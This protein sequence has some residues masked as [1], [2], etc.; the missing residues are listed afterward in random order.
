MSTSI[1]ASE[2]A[3]T[4]RTL[5]NKAK[6]SL[7]EKAAKSIK[8]HNT[9]VNGKQFTT[10]VSNSPAALQATTNNQTLVTVNNTKGKHY[11]L[12]EKAK[13][14]TISPESSSTIPPPPAS[15]APTTPP[16][17]LPKKKGKPASLANLNNARAN[18]SRNLKENRNAINA[19]KISLPESSSTIPPPPIKPHSNNIPPPPA[20]PAPTTPPTTPPTYLP[21]KKGKPASLAN[22]NNARANLSRNLKENRNAINAAKISLPPST[23]SS[24]FTEPEGNS[25]PFGPTNGGRRRKHQ[26]TSKRTKKSK[27]RGKT[28]HLRSS[29]S[30]R[31]S[32]K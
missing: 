8:K 11:V 12:V 13:N 4:A 10:S 7:N 32:R 2:A 21:K 26:K 22:L 25:D 5:N 19:A 1:N 15:P 23:T 24:I 28:R 27:S 3:L 29:R 9:T 20:S 18:L 6:T 30:S 17:N 14:T 16:T 31:N